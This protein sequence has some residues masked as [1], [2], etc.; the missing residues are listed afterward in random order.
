LDV[1]EVAL[2]AGVDKNISNPNT[3]TVGVFDS[4]SDFLGPH[5]VVDE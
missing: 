1:E 4:D 3:A 2:L 5:A